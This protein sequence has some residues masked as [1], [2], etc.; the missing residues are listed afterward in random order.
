MGTDAETDIPERALSW[1]FV[2]ARG[3]GGQHVNKASS[4]VELR[5]EV[6]ALG[7]DADSTRRLVR[8]AG[9]RVTADGIIVIQAD[10]H[11]SQQRNREA[12]LARIADLV[13]AARHKPRK[14]IATRPSKA[15]K[16]RR[17]E[18]KS[19]RSTVKRMRRPPD[20]E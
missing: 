2:R 6:A 10:E 3:P 19:R 16:Q 11:R 20:A 18:S 13:T 8:L 9:S 14:R 15:A 4:A 1:R 5:V 7:L 17:L 12:A